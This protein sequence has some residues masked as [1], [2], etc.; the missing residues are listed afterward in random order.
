MNTNMLEN[1]GIPLEPR[2]GCLWMW[3]DTAQSNP[4]RWMD[5]TPAPACTEGL[6][7]AGAALTGEAGT[8]VLSIQGKSL[9]QW[10]STKA[11]VHLPAKRGAQGCPGVL[12]LGQHLPEC[13]VRGEGPL[14]G[15]MG[16]DTAQG[17]PQMS[18]HQLSPAGRSG[19]SCRC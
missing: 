11:P 16:W 12:L 19:N 2:L 3:G 13:A 15:P 17:P 10:W 8:R 7:A 5:H 18:G 14:H 1:T 4:W 6:P 9:W